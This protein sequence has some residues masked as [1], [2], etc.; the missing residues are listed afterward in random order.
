[1]TPLRHLCNYLPFVT[2]IGSV[3]ALRLLGNALLDPAYLSLSVGEE[4]DSFHFSTS[5]AVKPVITFVIHGARNEHRYSA[6]CEFCRTDP[7]RGG[8]RRWGFSILL[9]RYVSAPFPDAISLVISKSGLACSPTRRLQVQIPPKLPC[10]G[11]H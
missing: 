10:I 2:R 4:L 7:R 8:E 5:S 6:D 11:K 3:I 1:M 9:P